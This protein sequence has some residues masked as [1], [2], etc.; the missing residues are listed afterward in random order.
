MASAMVLA[1]CWDAYDGGVLHV[2]TLFSDSPNTHPQGV[3]E[4][5]P[6]QSPVIKDEEKFFIVK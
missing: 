1:F 3:H 5:F 6:G 2:S 4:P